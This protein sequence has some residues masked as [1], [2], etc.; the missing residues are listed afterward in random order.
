MASFLKRFVLTCAVSTC[1]VS[2]YAENMRSA[3]QHAL[4]T[5]PALKASQADTRATAFE[6]MQL[7][8]EY[9]PVIDVYGEAGY[10]RIDDPENIS[11]R[12][13]DTTTSRTRLGVNA[14]YLIFDGYRRANT[15]YANAARVDGSIFRLLDAS[16]TMALNATEAYID[17]VRHQMLLAAAKRNVAKHQEI[18]R[19]V[20]DLVDGG[21][22]PFSDKL[23]IDDRINSARVA[24]LDVERALRDAIARYERV[25]GR[26]PSGAM[27]LHLAPVPR[28]LTELTQNAITNSYRVLF[29]QAQ[30]DQSTFQQD[31]ANANDAPRV[32]LN[33]GVSSERNRNG[34]SGERDEAYVG[35]GL[36]WTIY[37]GGRKAERNAAAELSYR[38]KSER[39]VAVR[40]VR[41]LSARTWNNY[42]TSAE[43]TRMLTQQLRINRMIVDVY[44]EEFDAAKRTLLDLLEVER[45]RFNVE[46]QK[47]SSEASLAFSTYRVLAAQSTLASHF[48]VPPSRLALEPIFQD[49]AKASTT[50]V[51]DVAI[52][53]LK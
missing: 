22:L 39:E 51:F 5:N 37:Q 2:A 28:T 52:E 45:A 13:N 10:Q 43:R 7:R 15:V 16:E 26:K 46:F 23:T 20:S 25:I 29:A 36:E 41:E 31:I 35:V 18:G 44:G 9:M 33:A 40:E 34:I 6:L 48:G 49:R 11:A 24:Q 47:I 27:H 38:A 19:R 30:V 53:P 32:T 21:R 3:V 8:G 50:S 12:E 4:T 17:V 14:E 42:R 1:A